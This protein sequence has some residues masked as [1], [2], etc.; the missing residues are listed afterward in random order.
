MKLKSLSCRKSQL[1]EK[2]EPPAAVYQLSGL[3]LTDQNK[4]ARPA[5]TPHHGNTLPSASQP[6]LCLPEE[7]RAA[8]ATVIASQD[9]TRAHGIHPGILAAL[10]NTKK[11]KKQAAVSEFIMNPLTTEFKKLG[12]KTVV[13]E[14]KVDYIHLRVNVMDE[15]DAERWRNA[16]CKQNKVTLKFEKSHTRRELLVKTYICLHGAQRR[17]GRKKKEF[18]G[19]KFEIELCIKQV[20]NANKRDKYRAKYPCIIVIKGTHNHPLESAIGLG[21]PRV[22]PETREFI[23]YFEMGMTTAQAHRHH[24]M[25]MDLCDDLHG[26]ANN[27]VN[28]SPKNIEHMRKVWLSNEEGRLNRPSMYDAMK[29]YSTDN[30]EVT[31]EIECDSHRYCVALVTPFMRR[32]HKQLKEAGEVVFVDT[33]SSVKGLNTAVI[34]FL[35]AGPAG[36]VPLAVLFTSSQDEVTLT[37]GFGMVKKVLGGNAFNGRGEP[38]SFM[39][40]SCDATREALAATWPTAQRFHCICHILQQVW[41]WLSDSKHGIEKH[42][43]HKLIAAVKTL[44]YAKSKEEF[45]E[46]WENIQA[47]PPAKTFPDF[48][49]YLAS[50][51]QRKEEWAIAYRAGQRGHHTN[52]FC[53][54]TMCV[55]KDIV[56]NKCKSF[57]LTSLV[58]YMVEIFDCYMRRRLVDV[59][60]RRRRIKP[61]SVGNLPIGTVT[62]LGH[63]KFSVR[64]Q[65]EPEHVY[66][67]DLT[68]G[69]CSCIKG[70]NSDICI[71]QTACADLSMTVEPQAF[72]STRE[73]QF[74]LAVLA[75]GHE[76]ASDERFLK[77]LTDVKIEVIESGAQ[78]SP[79]GTDMEVDSDAAD[80]VMPAEFIDVMSEDFIDVKTEDFI[81][82]EEDALAFRESSGFI[83]TINEAV[84][85]L[86]DTIRR[87]GNK[88]TDAYLMEFMEVLKSIKSTEE[89]N[90]FLTSFVQAIEDEVGSESI[91]C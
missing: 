47:N 44:V 75:V 37:K 84:K 24:V 21:Q 36:A 74:W 16:Y 32:A 64:S 54:A 58:V 4:A 50:L 55:I 48:T 17:L 38:Q 88:D 73:S 60:L 78:T 23:K 9:I 70:E 8:A 82:I 80:V 20:K 26:Q 40:D 42:N 3:S 39:T 57:K 11:E 31:L 83:A 66:T 25:K 91:P 76:K 72:V 68:I 59:A 5:S 79:N 65:Y 63:G 62:S 18:T 81:D 71:H 30:P 89:L 35:C 29:K 51:V 33:T 34:P 1:K 28:P 12:F 13:I 61:L 15:E 69:I 7:D 22:L 10:N 87:L 67:V 85:V 6:H 2:T 53:E 56:L 43:H 41:R 49:R 14:Q 52:N 19:C 45:S 46:V 27:A 86:G 77:N 90:N